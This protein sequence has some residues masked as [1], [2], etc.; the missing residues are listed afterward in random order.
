MPEGHTIHRLAR[1]LNAV[2]GGRPV[3]VSSPQGRFGADAAVVDGSVLEATDAH[4]KHLFLGFGDR[5]V[6]IH[7][8]LIG[9][10]DIVEAPAGPV[11]GAVRLRLATQTAHA[12][13][14]GP[15]VCELFGDEAKERVHARLGADPLRGD[16]SAAALDRI[17]RSR[18]SIGV[19][20]MDQAVLSGVGNVYRAEVLF[21]AGVAPVRPGREV[22]LDVLKA[23]WDDLTELMAIGVCAGQIDTV[24]PEHEPGAMGRE[25]RVDDHGGE[26]YV[27]RRAGLP[28][29]VCTTPV[30][31]GVMAARNVFWC[32]SC[33]H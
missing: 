31:A 23:I 30:R 6:H 25:P 4:G 19:L 27:Y 29:H 12:D 9:T 8:G 17:A 33:Q 3:D 28:C 18:T 5:W 14:R 16:D 32:P 24:R 22:P 15:T 26:V 13:L 1:D 20:L 21:R 2:F 11:R 10:F 7:L